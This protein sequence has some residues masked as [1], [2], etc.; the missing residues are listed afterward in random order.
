[1]RQY[2]RLHCIRIAS[3]SL[4]ATLIVISALS[5]CCETF[6]ASSEDLDAHLSPSQRQEND[7][8]NVLTPHITSWKASLYEWFRCLKMG[9]T[10][11]F[12][13]IHS[14]LYGFCEAK[15][16]HDELIHARAFPQTCDAMAQEIQSR[17]NRRDNLANLA[18]AS[19]CVCVIHPIVCLLIR[20][21]ILEFDTNVLVLFRR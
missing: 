15:Q 6:A 3:L 19:V 21:M 5:L 12:H 11:L 18:V 13:G 17:R 7:A 20:V 2:R 14:L 9:G 10:A 8:E 4:S 1:M 16:R